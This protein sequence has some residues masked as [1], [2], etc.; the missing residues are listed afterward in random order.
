MGLIFLLKVKSAGPDRVLNPP[1]MLCCIYKPDAALTKFNTLSEEEEFG[2][3]RLNKCL[4]IA[5]KIN[6]S[7]GIKT[8]F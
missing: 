3:G 1:D 2:H 8:V 6:I 5:T 4:F 7:P